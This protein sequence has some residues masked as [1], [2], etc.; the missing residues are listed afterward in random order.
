VDRNPRLVGRRQPL[1][2]DK[3]VLVVEDVLLS[4]GVLED[5]R[6]LPSVNG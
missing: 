5:P 2:R 3:L 6:M 1:A 4:L